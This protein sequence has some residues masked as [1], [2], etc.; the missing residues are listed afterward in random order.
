MV[1]EKVGRTILG[2]AAAARKQHLPRRRRHPYQW[3][4]AACKGISYI[5]IIQ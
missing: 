1:D 4:R 2:V 3:I 5:M